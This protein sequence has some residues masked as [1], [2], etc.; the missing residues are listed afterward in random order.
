MSTMETQPS[1]NPL[2]DLMDDSSV[3]EQDNSSSA[4]PLYDMSA[5]E[6]SA[7]NG[8]LLD[9][10]TTITTTTTTT[11]TDSSANPLYDLMDSEITE[12]APAQEEEDADQ[13]KPAE[14]D[15]LSSLPDLGGPSFSRGKPALSSEPVVQQQGFEEEEEELFGVTATTN[16]NNQFSAQDDLLQQ[17]QEEEEQE[18]VQEQVVPD[19]IP[20]QE[21][22][23]PQREEEEEELAG[24]AE[25][26]V[27]LFIREEGEEVQASLEEARRSR[28]RSRSPSN[29]SISSEGEV[30]NEVSVFPLVSF[31]LN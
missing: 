25:E 22:A 12:T 3:Q 21:T 19:V 18:E 1:A 14:E 9:F 26:N 29:H 11:T 31:A 5:T 10:E 28:S 6:Q 7:G 16:N 8:E 30:I 13:Q 17:Q 4:N 2:Y 23:P 15:F 24:G 20:Q 27:E